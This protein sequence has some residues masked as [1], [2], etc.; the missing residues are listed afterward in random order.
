M[1]A[2]SQRVPAS[3]NVGFRPR[4]PE[5]AKAFVITPFTTLARAHAVSAMAD[6]MVAASLAGSLFFSLPADNARGPVVKYLL[7]TMLPFA[8]ISPLIGPLIDRLKSGHRYVLLGSMIVRAVLCYLMISS[9]N[10]GDYIFF[11][12]ALGVLVG[13]KAYQVARSALVPTVVTGD[14]ELVTA[15]SRLSLISG[16]ASFVGVLPAAILL[17]VFGPQW[18]MGLAMVTFVVAA[19]LGVRIPKRRVA[20]A[21]ADATEKAELRS[22]GIVMA[23][24]AM[25]VL[26]AIV[27]FLTLALAF[28]FRG[29]HRP[30][31]QFA[32]VGGV[33]VAF[34]L[35]GSAT[36]PK[37]RSRMSEEN[38]LIGVLALVVV[39]GIA[40]LVL[41]DVAGGIVLGSCVGY[42]GTAGKVAFDSI[43]QR[44]APDANRGRSFAR[45]E[46][47]F[48][49]MWVI[50][51]FIPVAFHVG[52][53]LAFGIAFFLA[54][55][56]LA[57]YA[58]GRLAWAHR[59]GER[60][61]AATAAALQIDERFNEVSGEVKDRIRGGTRAAFNKVRRREDEPEE[62]P[63]HGWADDLG[64]D[65]PT[66][67][68]GP[69][70]PNSGTEDTDLV[71]RPSGTTPATS[72]R[73]GT[74]RTTPIDAAFDRRAEPATR[75]RHPPGPYSKPDPLADLDPFKDGDPFEDLPVPDDPD[76]PTRRT[77][78]PI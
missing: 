39:G 24:S 71:P 51:A 35:V 29:N 65:E 16:I 54:A 74:T 67:N 5:G 62:P 6:A 18:S 75:R 73:P 77:P 14:E 13:Q 78:G 34:G 3:S 48:Q 27:G 7:L 12:E 56:A 49:V 33:S 69:P 42:A 25:G 66:T 55:T 72:S 19:V 26:R 43:L 11:F 76:A 59:S 61:T 40:A 52:A 50:G 70:E 47:R 4:T 32:V 46:T 30:T 45:F 9:I 10:G 60:Q 37:L 31:W 58:I 22:A 36:A 57:S 20:S 64:E 41:G 68:Y 2:P 63:K 8:V 15:N 53:M 1:T 17:K 28:D 21:P 23:G 44:D 38:L